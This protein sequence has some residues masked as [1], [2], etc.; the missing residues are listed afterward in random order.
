MAG[1]GFC[2][3]NFYIHFNFAK[4]LTWASDKKDDDGET[5]RRTELLAFCII[6]KKGLKAFSIVIGPIKIMVGVV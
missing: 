4:T 2:L 1:I 3:W 6:E 5:M